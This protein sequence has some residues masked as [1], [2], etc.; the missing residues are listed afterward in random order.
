MFVWCYI[1]LSPFSLPPPPIPDPCGAPVLRCAAGIVVTVVAS[2][3]A[4]EL[5]SG[6]DRFDNP[7]ISGACVPLPAVCAGRG[8]GLV[9]GGVREATR[10]LVRAKCVATRF[11]PGRAGDW[12]AS[13]RTN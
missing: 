8:D 4:P 12:V 13:K 5:A 2:F 11:G 6:E 7:I 1:L 9:H 3:L 10:P